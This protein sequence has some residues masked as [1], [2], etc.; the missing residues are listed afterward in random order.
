MHRL[1]VG[2]FKEADKLPGMVRISLAAYNTRDEIDVLVRQLKKI[3]HK[4]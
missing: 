1:S 2:E 4:K 3:A